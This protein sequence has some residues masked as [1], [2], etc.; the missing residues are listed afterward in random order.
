LEHRAMS[1]NEL[2]NYPHG[3]AEAITLSWYRLDAQTQEIGLSLGLFALTPIRLFL[4]RMKDDEVWEI[5]LGDLLNLHL[6]K[7]VESGVYSLHPLVRE[8]LQIK[9]RE[10][11]EADELKRGFVVG[12]VGAAGKIPQNITL[13][14]VKELEVDIPHIMEVAKHL[15]EY[16][17]NDDLIIPFI[18][19]VRFYEAQG[20]YSQAETWLVKCKEIAEKFLDKDNTDVATLYNNLANLYNSQGK[21]QAAEPLYQQAIEIVK[22]ALPPNHPCLASSLNNL[23]NLYNS[24]GKYQAAEPL[25][26][27][28]IEIDKIA[29]PAN[30]P[31]L[32]THLNNLAGLYRAQGK[33]QSAEPL[34]LQALAILFSQLGQE[35]PNSQTVWRNYLKFLQQVARESRQQELS[36]EKSLQI[37]SEMENEAT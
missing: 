31:S 34:Y 14:Q 4:D 17:S 23:A 26:Q 15:I 30:H 2:I 8:F 6:V 12:M 33:Y 18:Q 3:V 37:L 13:E 32:A 28:A 27:Q 21:Y 35:H 36:D 25:Y 19:L 24:Q 10:D 11:P 7:N 1:A 29:L 20:F 5:A 22:I 16:L 9:L